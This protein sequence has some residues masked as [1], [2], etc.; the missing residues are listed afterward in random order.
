MFK[1]FSMK[2]LKLTGNNLTLK[3]I[4]QVARFF[5][6]VE[7]SD[8][9]VGNVNKSREIVERK[10]AGDELYY[11]LNTGFG[12]LCNVRISKNDVKRLQTNLLRS[13]AVGVGEPLSEEVVRSTMV[14]RINTLIQGN[15]GIRLEVIQ[16]LL[17]FL[18]KGIHPCVPAQGSV[19]ASGDLAPLAHMC[20]PLIGEGEVIY[21][22]VKMGA[23]E[24]MEK[25]GLRAVELDSK[26]GLALINGTSVMC[27]GGVL[28]LLDS[29]ALTK[30]ADISGAMSLEALKGKDT[31]LRAEIHKMRPHKGQIAAAANMKKVIKD[32]GIVDEYRDSGKLQDAYSMRC[33]PQVHGASRDALSYVRGVLEVEV[34][35]VTDN[36]LIILETEEIVSGGNFHGQPVA[37][38]MDFLAIAIAEIADI[39]EARVSRLINSRY[40]DL[41]AFLVENS[42]L[43]S[44]FMVAQ[45]TAA[46]LVSENKVLCHPACVDSI[47]TCAGQEDHVSMGSISARKAL[48][49]VAN[50]TNVIAIEFLAAAQGLEFLK[51]FKSSKPIQAVHELI[52][53]SVPKL[54]EDRRLDVEIGKVVDLMKKREI[55]RVVEE[56]VGKLE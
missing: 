15:S 11:G 39:A 37:L 19:G 13:H 51:P 2:T 46:A 5:V 17:D 54:V 25:N 32:S 49:V 4:E 42:G 56:I 53:E 8:V 43:N 16:L 6:Q 52:R 29:E 36:P 33:I 50:V 9:A 48:L 3:D 30:M 24:A 18:N 20:L 31:F 44:G 55:I 28:A 35:S 26:E 45:Y 40:S 7:L 14:I 34:N 1:P 22:G 23:A 27:G 21:K 38:A 47:P 10:L 12:D 41:P